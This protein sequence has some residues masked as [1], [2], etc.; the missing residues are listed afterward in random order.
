MQKKTLQGKKKSVALLFGGQS[1]EHEVSLVSAKCLLEAVD[2][3]LYLPIPIGISKAGD[4]YLVPEGKLQETSFESPIDFRLPGE[5][6][7]L[8][9]GV[10]GAQLA[11]VHGQK[12]SIHIDFAFPIVH[13]PLGEDGSLQG[14]FRLL[15]I[16]FAGSDLS[17]SALCMDKEFTK[18]VLHSHQIP[19][20]NFVSLRKNQEVQYEI[21]AKKLGE[22]FYIKPCNMGSSIGVHK[23]ST[24]SE[25]QGALENAFQ[26]DDK[27]LLESFVDG[28]EVE[29]SVLGNESPRASSPGSFVASQQFYN[30]ETKYLSQSAT[31]FQIP[32]TS[33]EALNQQ[34]VDLALETYGALGCGGFARVDFFIT[35]EEKILVNEVNT[36]PGF[37]PISMYPLL[38]R[39]SGVS[40]QD[41]ITEIIQLGEERHKK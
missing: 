36:L 13:G 33:D 39:E 4:W 5:E 6:V 40:F 16:P 7:F 37:T 21:L 9:P 3:E 41:L 12:N 22:T 32:A 31:Q 10:K 14:L 20:C 38:W 26:F 24:E 2:R 8:V 17:A 29:V 25:F 23:V 15:G 28:L 18:R 35:R 11:K 1:A 19:T 34:I 27:L 30:Y